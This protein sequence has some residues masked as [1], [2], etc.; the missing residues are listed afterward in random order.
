MRFRSPF[1]GC[2]YIRGHDKSAP[3][4]ADGLPIMLQTFHNNATHTLL[5][6]GKYKKETP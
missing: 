5:F 6:W 2:L 1:R 3:T 4:A